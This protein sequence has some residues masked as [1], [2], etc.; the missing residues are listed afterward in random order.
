M[1]IIIKENTKSKVNIKVILI[2][3]TINNIIKKKTVNV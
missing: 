3:K 1:P 2:I